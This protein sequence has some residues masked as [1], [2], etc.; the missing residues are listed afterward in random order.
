MKSRLDAIHRR[1]T[2]ITGDFMLA[3]T[4]E[5]SSWE[6]ARVGQIRAIKRMLIRDW[7]TQTSQHQTRLLRFQLR[8]PCAHSRDAL[9]ERRIS[10]SP[11]LVVC[12]PETVTPRPY[13]ETS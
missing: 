10:L 2:L 11:K 5:G 3:G 13:L 7:F 8:P 12:G 1:I 9:V 6:A 4:S